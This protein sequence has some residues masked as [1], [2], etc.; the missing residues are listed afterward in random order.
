MEARVVAKVRVYDRA[1][2]FRFEIVGK[3]AG[4][5]VDDVASEWIVTLRDSFHRKFTVDISDMSG[6]DN[7]G[8]RLLRDMH[9]Y[10]TQFACGTPLSLAF[11]SEISA[12][13][14]TAQ[15]TVMPSK[16][17]APHKYGEFEQAAARSA[18]AG[19]R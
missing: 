6:Y 15:V 19:S 10:G 13:L 1:D 3:F 11:F 14:K 17:D 4:G 7:A 18:A 2:E 9:K 8:R 16:S 12:P 5:C